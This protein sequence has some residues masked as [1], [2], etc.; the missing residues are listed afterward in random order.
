[1]PVCL[2]FHQST[3]MVKS[4]RLAGVKSGWIT[5][6]NDRVSDSSGFRSG[7]P[8]RCSATLRRI[9]AVFTR[10]LRSSLIVGATQR[11]RPVMAPAS[12][13]ASQ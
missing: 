2:M 6:P 9:R 1:M 12:F 11:F 10:G 13:N 8:A 3:V 7:L 5:V 4:P